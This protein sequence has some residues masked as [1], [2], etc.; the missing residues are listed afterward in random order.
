MWCWSNSSWTVSWHHFSLDSMNKSKITT[1]YWLRKKN[2]K[3]ACIQMFIKNLI[4]SWFDDRSYCTLYF[5]TSL[6]DLDLDSRSQGCEKANTSAPIISQRFLFDLNRS[7]FTVEIDG[8]MNL[9]L[10]LCQPL[11]M[12]IA[13]KCCNSRFFTISSLRRELSPAR[14]FKWP[15]HSRVQITSRVPNQ[16]GVSQAWYRVEIHHS[17][18]KPLTCNTWNVCYVQYFV[19]RATQYKRR[20]SSAIKFD[21]V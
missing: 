7:W 15:G 1:V 3:L 13:F 18:R 21:R 12:I 2:F 5:D 19:L 20:D 10:A 16:N 17:G 4:K 11:I 14:T 8:L 9:S 6:I